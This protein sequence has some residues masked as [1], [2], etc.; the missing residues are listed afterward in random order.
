MK[1]VETAGGCQP[2]NPKKREVAA[3]AKHPF[4]QQKSARGPS[5]NLDF[6]VTCPLAS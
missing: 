2:E 1:T 4:L 3:R 6:G 5:R